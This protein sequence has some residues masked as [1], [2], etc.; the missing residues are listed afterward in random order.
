M[1]IDGACHCGA[2]TLEGEADPETVAICHCTDCQTSTGTAFRISIPVSGATLKMTGQPATYL[3]TTADV[4]AD[5]QTVINRMLPDLS[6]APADVIAASPAY[7][8]PK[9]TVAKAKPPAVNASSTA[10]MDE[11][12]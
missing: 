2:I 5:T 3:K 1:R 6:N 11:K 8:T 9:T 4:I 12:K 7:W 10:K